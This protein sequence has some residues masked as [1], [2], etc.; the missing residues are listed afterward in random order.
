MPSFLQNLL[1]LPAKT[2]AILGVSAVAILAIAF[3]MLKVATAP[4][5]STIASGLDPAETGKITAALDEQGIAYEIQNNGTALAVAKASTAQARIA[6]AGA[7]VQTSGGGNQPGYE[8]LDES[9]L[10]ASQF[11][12]QVTYQRALEGEIA[13]TLS[14]VSGV[15]SPTVQIVIPQDDLFAD[16]ASPATA[17]VMLGNSADTLQPGAVRGMAQVVASSV[18]SLK[19]E[20]V[21]ITDSTGAVLWPSAESGG[22]GGGTS[23]AAAEARYAR[24]LESSINGMLASTLGPGKAQVKVNADLNMDETTEKELT[25]GKEG[26][27]LSSTEDTETLSGAGAANAGGTAGTGSNVPTYS[28]RNGNGNGD[29]DGNADSSY[30]SKKGSTEFGVDKKVRDTKIAGGAVNKLNVALLVDQ[31]VDPK[32]FDAL[33]T[34]VSAAAGFDAARG[35]TLQAAQMAFAK[36]EVPKAGPVPTTLLGPLKWVGLG[37]ASLLFLFFM[38]R[39]LKKREG[40]NL[41]TPAWL[42]T[43]DEPVSLAQLEAGQAGGAYLDG[44][45]TAM[46]PPRVPDTSLHQ[47]DQLMEREPE[48]VAAQVKAWMA[49]D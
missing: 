49:E 43:I 34:T 33:K 32:V 40:E 22:A 29:G 15:Q 31:S 45:A 24:Q 11:Q 25:Y 6:L 17:A 16:E 2:K 44:A 18:K 23:K 42:T 36:P 8:L 12:Q 26:V 30:E 48:R 4:S 10:G 21:T 37:L 27:P 28:G 46:L 35:D 3:L 1:A 5:Y 41:G 19:T 47:L 20:N 38:T 39:G 9:K 13:R 14:G 7:G